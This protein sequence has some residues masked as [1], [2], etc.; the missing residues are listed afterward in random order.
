MREG[1][2]HI[3]GSH[4]FA[5]FRGQ[6]CA[7]R[8][9]I[10]EIHRAGIGTAAAPDLH[11][12]AIAGSGFLRHM[13][14]NVVGTLVDI[15]RGKIPPVRMRELLEL[16]D[17]TLAGATAPA[18]GLF[19]WEVAYECPPEAGGGGEKAGGRK[20]FSLD[21]GGRVRSNISFDFEAKG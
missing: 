17:R 16:G 14:R 4:D 5:S 21:A 3:A 1:L 6:R 18:H 20:A 13:V 10:R 7:A 2:A 8:T 19:L 11:C 12:V 9:T 15:G